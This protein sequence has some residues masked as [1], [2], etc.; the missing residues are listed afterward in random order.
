MEPVG[1]KLARLVKLRV[2]RSSS[3]TVLE[4]VNPTDKPAEMFAVCNVTLREPT[5]AY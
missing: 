5:P 1:V 4:G 2:R 3:V